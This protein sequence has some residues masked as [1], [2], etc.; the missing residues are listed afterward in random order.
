M[1]EIP[2]KEF[3]DYITID[4]KVKPKSSSYKWRIDTGEFRVWLTSSASKGKAN[5][6]LITKIS[7]LLKIPQSDIRIIKGFKSR[8]KT[9]RIN[10]IKKEKIE[11]MLK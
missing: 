4:I 2:I 8:N 7:E 9:I 1:A 5:K 6:E 10:S 3:D 11:D